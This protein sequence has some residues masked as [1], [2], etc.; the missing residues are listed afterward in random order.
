MGPCNSIPWGR[1]HP[2]Q[3]TPPWKAVS[4]VARPGGSGHG[5]PGASCQDV[6][7]ALAGREQAV[8]GSPGCL[9]VPGRRWGAVVLAT[10][11]FSS[12]Q[13]PEVKTGGTSGLGVWVREGPWSPKVA[14]EFP[15]PRRP[16][17][18]GVHI[19]RTMREAGSHTPPFG[20]WNAG[21]GGS[22]GWTFLA[23]QAPWWWQLL[24]PCLSHVPQVGGCSWCG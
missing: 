7:A 4:R 3:P 10:S 6:P 17:F 23:G 9:F 5:P 16:G 12:T 24:V 2:P 20:D 19:S 22:R 18:L 21:G 8:L 14:E 13:S 1:S 11:P 15:P